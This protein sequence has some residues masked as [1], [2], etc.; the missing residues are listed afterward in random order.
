QV[1]PVFLTY[2]ARP[3]IDALIAQVVAGTP[4]YDFV[5][6][7]GNRHVFWV[8]KEQ[9]MN[10]RIQQAFDAVDC[11]Y[12]ADGHHRSAAAQ[13]VKDLRKNANPAHTGEEAYNWF[14][15]VIFP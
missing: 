8:V 15:T 11:L 12:V 4:E 2:R 7:D 5:A 1:G 6:D 10:D 14:S 13:R 3:E 9:A